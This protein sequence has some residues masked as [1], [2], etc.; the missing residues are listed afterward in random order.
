MRRCSIMFVM[1]TIWC[2]AAAA[3]EPADTLTDEQ[4]I[5]ETTSDYIE[6]WYEGNPIRMDRAL[7]PDLAKRGL[8]AFE[9]TGGTILSH[10]SAST[11]VEYTKAGLGKLKPDETANI[12]IEVLDIDK[13]IA[14][15]KVSSVKFI[16]YI[17]LARSEGRW[18]IVNVLWEPAMPPAAGGGR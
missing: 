17:H 8:R 11:M 9:K 14:S 1:V 16:D 4:L 2:V 13:N 18:Q 10:A 15:V 6:G 12:E 5:I 7:H 3:Q